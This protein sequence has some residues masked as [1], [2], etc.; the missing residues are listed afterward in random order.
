MNNEEFLSMLAETTKTIRN[1]IVQDSLNKQFGNDK[2]ANVDKELIALDFRTIRAPHF[3]RWVTDNRDFQKGRYQKGDVEYDHFD[4]DWRL[5]NDCLF[6]TIKIRILD[7]HGSA[8]DVFQDHTTE[9][10]PSVSGSSASYAWRPCK[11]NIGTACTRTAISTLFVYKNVFVQVRAVPTLPANSLL[12]D[13]LGDWTDEALIP[14]SPNGDPWDMVIA[15]WVYGI[16]K[17]A[18]CFKI[19][20]AEPKSR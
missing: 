9:I 19:F 18:P 4:F 13:I 12:R 14:K 17:T 20:P 15:E 6:V 5:I 8:H 3:E 16:L 10:A 1:P 2:S 11:K 7:N